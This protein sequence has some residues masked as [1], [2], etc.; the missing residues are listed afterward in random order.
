MSGAAASETLSPIE[1]RTTE[2][3]WYVR[4]DVIARDLQVQSV[5]VFVQ[6]QARCTFYRV[7]EGP[8]LSFQNRRAAARR[9]YRISYPHSQAVKWRLTTDVSKSKRKSPAIMTREVSVPHETMPGSEL[10]LMPASEADCRRP[11]DNNA[12]GVGT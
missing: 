12:H 8:F 2:A 11:D 6:T 7:D 5:E 4:N 9:L 3:G 1:S 10:K